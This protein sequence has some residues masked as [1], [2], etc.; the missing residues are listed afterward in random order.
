MSAR[1]QRVGAYALSIDE[2][3]GVLLC[4][5]S[6][7]SRTP[8]TLTLPGGGVRHGEDPGDAV[9]REL[10]EETGLTGRV[11]ALLGVH[12]NVYDSDGVSI[13]GVRLL[14]QVTI[15]GGTLRAE[16]GDASTDG[17]TWVAP[18]DLGGVTLSA[19]ARHALELLAAASAG[20]S[21]S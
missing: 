1:R 5:M 4:R 10:A 14:Y 9:L 20:T 6:R 18:E 21:R 17:A 13:H 7:R 19:H 11:E 15:V 3:G 16:Q 8:G 12:A 2:A